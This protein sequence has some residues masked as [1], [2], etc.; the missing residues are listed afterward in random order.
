MI[1]EEY[2]S[3][4]ISVNPIHSFRRRRRYARA[5]PENSSMGLTMS[6]RVTNRPYRRTP[7]STRLDCLRTGRSYQQVGLVGQTRGLY[8]GCRSRGAPSGDRGRPDP[9]PVRIV[10]GPAPG[11]QAEVG[12]PLDLLVRLHQLGEPADDNAPSGMGRR[13]VVVRLEPDEVLVADRG[14]LRPNSC[15]KNY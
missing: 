14:Q 4:W 7:P 5:S 12:K 2:Q 15:P 13:V 10:R 11:L 3:G 9:D 8:G 6:G 1:S